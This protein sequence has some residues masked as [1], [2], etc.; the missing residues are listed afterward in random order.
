MYLSRKMTEESLSAIGSYFGGRDHTTIIHACNK[1]ADDLKGPGG[2]E[3]RRSIEDMER[4]IN[5]E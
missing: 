2:E 5:G 4:R 3:L 1:I